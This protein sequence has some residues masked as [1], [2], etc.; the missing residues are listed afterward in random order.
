MTVFL[1]IIAILKSGCGPLMV[2][3]WGGAASTA[4]EAAVT[5][6]IET[7]T[8]EHLAILAIKAEHSQGKFLTVSRSRT[9][10]IEA[11]GSRLKNPSK[12]S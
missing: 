5:V 6:V 11:F 7:T 12:I 10:G 1:R 4:A 9:G 2:K 8:E 3:G